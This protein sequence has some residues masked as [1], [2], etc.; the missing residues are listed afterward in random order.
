MTMM[1]RAAIVPVPAEAD[2]DFARIGLAG[3]VNSR[4][5]RR[6]ALYRMRRAS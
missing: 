6:A 3:D 1:S 2:I 5:S 4:G